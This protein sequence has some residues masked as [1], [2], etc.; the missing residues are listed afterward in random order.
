MAEGRRFVCDSCANA[1][2]AWGDG[3]P[4]Y[5]GETGA[6]IYAYHPSAERGRC[7]GNDVPHL[8]LECG[9][10]FN[11]DSNAPCSECVG[12][13]SNRIS[14]LLMLEG[15]T[16]PVCRSGRFLLDPEFRAVS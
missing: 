6:K 14:D 9:Q 10:E 13:S 11:V 16:C 1:V 5:I 3:N 7:I 4:Y 12:C 15:H 8:C 2:E